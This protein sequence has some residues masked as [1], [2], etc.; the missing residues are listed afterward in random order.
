MADQLSVDGSVNGARE[1]VDVQADVIPEIQGGIFY[2]T[3]PDDPEKLRIC[4]QMNSI[5]TEVLLEDL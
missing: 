2:S 4:T 5:S 1:S 3:K